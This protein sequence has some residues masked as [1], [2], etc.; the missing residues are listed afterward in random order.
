[1]ADL[2]GTKTEKNLWEAFAGESMARN[3]YTFF[4]GKAKKDGYEQIAGIFEE[5]AGNEREHAKMWYKLLCGGNIPSTAEN[6]KAA[7][8]GEN[9]EWT[10]MYK[11]M[12]K[13][14]KEEGF[15]KIALLFEQVGDIEKD[16]EERY[17]KLLD[18]LN[19][20][21]VFNKNEKNVWI[22]RNCGHLVDAESAPK[23]CRVCA[24]PQSYFELRCVNY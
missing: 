4:A 14:A 20:D 15:D 1:M 10:A 8:E 17:L 13:E 5:T 2:K 22:C 16:H 24:H 12:A 23:G 7:A 21:K 9:E 18:N 19:N 6:L 11:R 3:K